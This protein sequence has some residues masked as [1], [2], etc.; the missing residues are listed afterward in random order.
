MNSGVEEAKL[1]L[2]RLVG[3]FAFF[4]TIVYFLLVFAGLVRLTQGDHVPMSTW[5]LLI[6]AGV[7]FVPAVIDGLNL[8]RISDS[9]RLDRLWKSCGIL[10]VSGVVL[11]VLA[12]FIAG[13]IDS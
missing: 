6:P 5:L 7:A 10:T 1:M 9:E 8:H 12:A 3:K 13:G 4:F 2:K 11:L